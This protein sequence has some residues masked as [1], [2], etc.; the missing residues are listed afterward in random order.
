MNF[1]IIEG[2]KKKIEISLLNQR[3]YLIVI[4]WMERIAFACGIV[5]G[6]AFM[7]RHLLAPSPWDVTIR[8][9]PHRNYFDVAFRGTVICASFFIIALLLHTLVKKLSSLGVSERTDEELVL[10][11]GTLFYSFRLR[12]QSSPADRNR[13]VVRLRDIDHV[14]YDKQ[15]RKL[16][17]QG[18][19]V[20]ENVSKVEEAR[21][22]NEPQAELRR[23]EIYD[24]FFPSLA[25]TFRNRAV[26]IQCV[27][28]G[29]KGS[30]VSSQN[31]GWRGR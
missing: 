30:R 6:P 15:Q 10:R 8:G 22:A 13:I 31:G 3:R 12:Y 24:Y 23:M 14:L 27:E 18:K 9:E 1:K 21:Q 20:E 17:I 29:G 25:E 5:I 2:E 7:L 4:R 16:M 19:I 11:E 28:A 26:N